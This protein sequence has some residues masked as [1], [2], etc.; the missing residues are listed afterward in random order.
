M[1]QDDGSFPQASEPRLRIPGDA[2]FA[3]G[4][5]EQKCLPGFLATVGRALPEVAWVGGAVAPS[6]SSPR[7]KSAPFAT[8][9]SPGMTTITTST[10]SDQAFVETGGS[11]L[12]YDED[13]P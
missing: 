10:Q 11:I 1:T 2:Q 12:E 7:F 6:E 13:E 3:G 5:G 4:P 9:Y 8:C